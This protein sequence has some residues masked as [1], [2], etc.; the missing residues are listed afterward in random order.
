MVSLLPE[1]AE[2][3]E[4]S[5]HADH[6]NGEVAEQPKQD[7]KHSRVDMGGE[8]L[9]P[10]I[11]SSASA[12]EIE[13]KAIASVRGSRAS[14]NRIAPA[15]NSIKANAAPYRKGRLKAGPLPSVALPICETIL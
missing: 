10:Q 15:P 1:I 2:N 3:R 12:R 4:V 13:A 8:R 7:C 14:L 11:A 6:G 9:A 5:G